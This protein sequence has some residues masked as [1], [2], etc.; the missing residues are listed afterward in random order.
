MRRAKGRD[1]VTE[2]ETPYYEIIREID[3]E[4]AEER[5]FVI[6]YS[7]FEEMRSA[8]QVRNEEMEEYHY[9]TLYEE[10]D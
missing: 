3:L 8:R 6:E 7:S 10:W 1:N 2:L 9:I 4:T 5:V